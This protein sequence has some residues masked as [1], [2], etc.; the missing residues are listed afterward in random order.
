M[1]QVGITGISTVRGEVRDIDGQPV[2]EVQVLALSIGRTTR[3]GPDGRFELDGLPWGED[4]ILFRRLGFNPVEAT[5]IIDAKDEELV[6]RMTP[7]AHELSP[8]VAHGRRSGMLGTVTDVVDR[9]IADVEVMVLG[10]AVATRTDSLGRFSLPSV[11][12]GTFMMMARKRGYFVVRRSVTL[13]AGEALEVSVLLAQ[14]SSGLSPQTI[15]RLAGI[16]GTTSIP[17]EAH[18]SRRVRCAGGNAVFVPREEIA[19]QGDL[20]LDDALPKAPS[21]S[22]RGMARDDLRDYAMFI[23]GIGAGWPL[24]SIQAADV[25]GVEVYR[26]S[27]YTRTLV[28]G[29]RSRA[30]TTTRGCPSGSIWVWLR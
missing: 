26:S 13:P 4:R 15:D 8:I 27:R 14:V 17:W 10:G 7:I 23:D 22:S 12:A 11:P 30:F 20:R 5:I 21:I 3:T 1:A 2:D 29:A 24:S 9:P 6:V 18:V 25:E 19:V 16:G 28:S